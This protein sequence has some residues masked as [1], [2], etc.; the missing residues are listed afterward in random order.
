MKIRPSPLT[1]PTLTA[2]LAGIVL[3]NTVGF[4]FC[5]NPARQPFTAYGGN[6]FGWPFTYLST[7]FTASQWQQMRR[8]DGR[9]AYPIHVAIEPTELFSNQDVVVFSGRGLAQNVAAWCAILVYAAVVLE[10]W[11]RQ[12]RRSYPFTVRTIL[13][14]M[15]GICLIAGLSR[16]GM[17]YHW[18]YLQYYKFWVLGE[19]LMSIAALCVGVALAARYWIKVR[20]HG[21][22]RTPNAA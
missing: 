21:S 9:Y 1:I 7:N 15:T 3:L 17:F 2:L 14:L 12:C 16:S 13:I 19:Q 20:R 4:P 22:R 11:Q 8:P 6:D 5:E 18:W 10:L